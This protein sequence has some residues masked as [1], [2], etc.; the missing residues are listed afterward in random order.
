MQIFNVIIFFKLHTTENSKTNLS[1]S[2]S[3]Q[4]VFS[5][6]TLVFPIHPLGCLELDFCSSFSKVGLYLGRFVYFSCIIFN[7]FF[8]PLHSPLPSPPPFF[9]LFF[10][11]ILIIA[12]YSLRHALL[13]FSSR[14]SRALFLLPG[15]WHLTDKD[16]LVLLFSVVL[17]V[18]RKRWLH[19]KCARFV[20]FHLI[21]K[22][23][24]NLLCVLD[25]SDEMG[26]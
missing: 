24:F 19:W 12:S 5:P 11:C 21:K 10:W 6:G 15:S 14:Q 8:F 18:A 22:H 4:E 9:S 25:Q 16:K 17:C 1:L 2:I 3:C 20:L 13:L 26:M 7:S 23:S